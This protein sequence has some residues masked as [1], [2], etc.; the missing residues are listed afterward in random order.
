VKR[1]TRFKR[2]VP[3]ATKGPFVPSHFPNLKLWCR[4]NI[5]VEVTSLGVSTWFDQ[6]GNGNDLLQSTDSNRP[7]KE[8][9]GSV[10]F[11]GVDNYIA[12]TFTLNQSLTVYLLFNPVSYSNNGYIFDGDTQNTC[13]VFAQGGT[14][15]YVLTAGSSMAASD[16][17]NAGTYVV[18]TSVFN[19]T[20]SVHQFNNNIDVT[21]DAGT[22][23]AAG[24]TLGC[25]GSKST[26]FSNIQVKEVAIYSVA[27]TAGQRAKVIQ[28]L[29]D[30]G[31]LGL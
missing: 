24:F 7:S 21:G 19:S 8:S 20:T 4:Y 22:N 3:S 10:L 13:L 15:N 1:Q 30:V 27:H 29:S 16:A 12:A 17:H 9:D 6:S 31:G 25:D 23:N 14:D 28:Y 26:N 11:D 5:G 2:P 18:M